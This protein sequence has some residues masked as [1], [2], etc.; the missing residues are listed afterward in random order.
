MLDMVKLTSFSPMVAVLFIL[1]VSG[2]VSWGVVEA[3]KRLY[4]A[5]DESHHEQE[6]WWW[7]SSLRAL[8][9]I[10]GTAVGVSFTFA[11]VQMLLALFVGL[12]G[13]VLNTTIVAVVRSKLSKLPVGQCDNQYVAS[14]VVEGTVRDAVKPSDGPDGVQ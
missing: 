9:C 13:G 8:A 1:A 3:L 14:P 7:S 11:G 5:Y 4:I 2:V 12:C 10:I 6:P